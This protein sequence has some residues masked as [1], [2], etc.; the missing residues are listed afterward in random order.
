MTERRTAFLV[1][2]IVVGALFIDALAM[3]Q[4]ASARRVRLANIPADVCVALF[5]PAHADHTVVHLRVA[6]PMR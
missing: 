6:G 5:G 2:V 1:A 4:T 3:H